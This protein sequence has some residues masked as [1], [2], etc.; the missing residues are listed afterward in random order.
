MI[1][2]IIVREAVEADIPAYNKIFMKIWGGKDLQKIDEYFRKGIS[3]FKHGYCIASIDN[4][5][6]GTGE[7]F[8]IFNKLPIKKMNEIEDP[9]DIYDPI[10][11]HYFIRGIAVLPE[12]RKAG[13]G[14]SLLKYHLDIAEKLACTQVCGIVISDHIDFWI[15]KGFQKEG[16]WYPYKNLGC[17]IWIN[18]EL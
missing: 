15:K 18:K 12:Y 16:K 9:I 13:A 1:D 14:N 5:L 17:F 11:E 10:G 3:I 8:P 7:G 4:K 2:E 6:I